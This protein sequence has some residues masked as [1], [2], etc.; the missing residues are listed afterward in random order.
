[1]TPLQLEHQA[2]SHFLVYIKNE[3][4]IHPVDFIQ[5]MVDNFPKE[6][7]LVVAIG[8]LGD[9]IRDFLNLYYPKRKIT[10]VKKESLKLYLKI[11]EN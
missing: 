7:K 2:L 10:F 11:K 1:M 6:T 4:S 9:Q 5:K 8:H 3:F